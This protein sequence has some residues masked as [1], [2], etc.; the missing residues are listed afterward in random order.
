MTGAQRTFQTELAI[1]LLE[2]VVLDVI[3]EAEGSGATPLDPFNIRERSPIAGET[4]G[5]EFIHMIGNRLQ[6]QGVIINIADG[7][8]PQ[9]KLADPT[10]NRSV[11]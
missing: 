9:W 3:V 1:R 6:A 4:Q 7:R 8:N 2:E 5:I 10:S 11:R